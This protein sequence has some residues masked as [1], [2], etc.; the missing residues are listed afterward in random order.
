[1]IFFGI[2]NNLPMLIIFQIILKHKLYKHNIYFYIFIYLLF[3]Y[4]FY[5]PI[6]I[7]FSVIL[8]NMYNIII[9]C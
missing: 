4:F 5:F 6:L 8:H 1:M 3:N 2:N 7:T 9:S